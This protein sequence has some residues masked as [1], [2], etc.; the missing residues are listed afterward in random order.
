MHYV[1][2]LDTPP[3][4]LKNRIILDAAITILSYS[5]SFVPIDSIGKTLKIEFKIAPSWLADFLE[6]TGK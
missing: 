3:S 4:D 5:D 6:K 2:Y 1:L